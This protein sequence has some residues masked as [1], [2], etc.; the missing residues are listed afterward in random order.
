MW[1]S[2]YRLVPAETVL[3]SIVVIG[4]TLERLARLQAER[5][6]AQRPRNFGSGYAPLLIHGRIRG[7]SGFSLGP[8]LAGNANRAE[9]L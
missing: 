5:K 2:D 7:V 1:D 9:S 8:Y 4:G 3:S 6:A